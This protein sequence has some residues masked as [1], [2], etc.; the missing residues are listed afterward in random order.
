MKNIFLIAITSFCLFVGSA[1]AQSTDLDKQIGAE[2]SKTVETEMG[3]YDHEEMT[4]YFNKVGQKLVSHL[5][6]PLFDY[7]FK[8]VPDM[9]PN[10]FALPGGYIY[11]T[12]GILP[13]LESEDELAGI[14]GHEIIHSNNR[15]SI[16]QMKKSILPHIL[17]IPGNLLGVISKP[18]GDLVN[19]PIKVSSSLISSSYSRGF[20]TEA[21]NYGVRLAA[22]A[23]YDPTKL[24]D[25]LK[26][27]NDAI[28]VLTGNKEEKSYF[29]DHPYTPKRIENLNKQFKEIAIQPTKNVSSSFLYEFDGVLFG[30]SPSKGIVRDNEFLHPDLNF[31]VKFPEKWVIDNQSDLLNAYQPDGKAAASLTIESKGLTPKEAGHKFLEKIDSKFKTN[32]TYAKEY[33][34]NGKKGFLISFVEE[35][36]HEKMYAYILWL[37]QGNEVF[38]LLGVAPI[39]YQSD[40]EASAASLRFMTKEEKASIKETFVKVVK[41]NKGETTEQLSKRTGNKLL[42]K[43]T[44]VANDHTLSDKLSEG[45]LIKIVLERPYKT[46]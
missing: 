32:I 5:E 37:P 19:A 44:A 10:A 45:E 23:G 14:I 43:L 25:V 11:I 39:E 36:K 40:L 8:I 34:V 26:R 33:E 30:E 41:A 21:D 9:S 7:K 3:I 1:Q 28:E 46:K 4:A 18:V 17:E 20:E 31:Y 16:K 24:P 15:H 12:T 35:S 27:M 38:K 42:I 2:N 6:K 22:K 29:S 13:L